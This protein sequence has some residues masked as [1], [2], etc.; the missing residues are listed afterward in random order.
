VYERLPDAD[1]RHDLLRRGSLLRP[2]VYGEFKD[3]EWE[4]IFPSREEYL[5]AQRSHEERILKEHGLL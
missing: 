4:D 2:K 3:Y 1:T 5:D